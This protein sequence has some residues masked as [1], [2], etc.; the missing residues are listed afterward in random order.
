MK[1]TTDSDCR[2]RKHREETVDHLASGC[3]ILMK[4]E[5]LLRQDKVCAHLCYSVC[6]ALVIETTDVWHTHTHTN[7]HTHTETSM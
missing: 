7:T 4:T 1:E 3:P 2:L 5:Y 6:K